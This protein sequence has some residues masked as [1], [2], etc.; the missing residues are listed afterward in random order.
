MDT[1]LIE[2]FVKAKK[3]G[4][5][6]VA[7]KSFDPQATMQSIQA[8]YKNLENEYD[9][10]DNFKGRRFPIIQWDVI[11]G[12]KG[13][14][15]KGT[16]AVET[17]QGE[18]E[19]ATQNPVECLEK[20][21]ELPEDSIL[22]ILNAHRHLKEDDPQFAQALWNLRDS[23]K[24]NF[25]TVVLLVPDLI[26][27]TELQQDVLVLDEKLP[28]DKALEKI[29]IDL[30]ESNGVK[31]TKS[32]IAESINALRGISAYPAEQAV[33]MS[34]SRK[35]IDI[36]SLWD[37]KKQLIN[38]THG[39][40]IWSDGIKFDNLGGL[41]FLKKRFKRIQKGKAKPRVIVWIDEIEKAMAGAGTDSSGTSTDQLGVLLTEI[42]E[43]KYNGAMFVGVPGAAKSA[44][45]KAIGNEME[46]L[47]IKLDLGGM[48]HHYVG[49][50][51]ARIR[52]AMKIIEAVGGKGGAFFIVTS[53]DISVLKPEL[54]RRFK[55]G[56]W[57]FDLPTKVERDIIWKLYI[58]KFKLDPKQRAKVKDE[59]W[60]GAE[61]ESC[62]ETAWE[63]DITL[64]QASETIIPVARSSRTM[65]ENLRH[66]ADN[67]YN[68]VSTPG[69]FKMKIPSGSKAGAKKRR[70]E[71]N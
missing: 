1:Q 69:V 4:T 44:A 61:I 30:C 46:I 65:V 17:I 66:E 70:M 71:L 29:I 25:R 9:K 62:C 41:E 32:N 12:M 26:L 8:R 35:G 68:D 15:E 5:S 67:K 56:I 13:R 54:K 64:T 55:K 48:K 49:A 7:I 39:L 19:L 40:S 6:L 53:N 52:M 10:T 18:D 22:F 16:Q 58:K 20:A 23:F 42:Q 21:Q 38:E 43:K 63:E 2:K 59:D 31:A 28:D 33:A 14:N 34:L 3:A 60:T 50:S 24:S 57:Y 51:E 27:P 47:T 37:R 45:A 11:R 36:E